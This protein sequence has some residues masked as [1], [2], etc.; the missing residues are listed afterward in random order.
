MFSPGLG[1]Q[2]PPNSAIRDWEIVM[3]NIGSLVEQAYYLT[4]RAERIYTTNGTENII[5]ATKPGVHVG[6]SSFTYEGATGAHAFALA[7][8]DWMENMAL[9][10]S[11][12]AAARDAEIGTTIRYPPPFDIT[13]IAIVSTRPHV[14]YIAPVAFA[15]EPEEAPPESEPPV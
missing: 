15:I 14:P 3:R 8:I 11:Y 6:D 12:P 9:T 2:I 5:G 1:P 13:P 7:F 4:M 10:I